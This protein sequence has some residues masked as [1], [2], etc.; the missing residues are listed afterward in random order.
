MAMAAARG[1]SPAPTAKGS[2]IAPTRATEGEGHRNNEK[3]SMVRPKIHQ[4][5]EGF[6]ITWDMGRI[7][8]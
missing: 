4:V 7:S 3:M 2:M 1:F 6:F 8:R 5:T